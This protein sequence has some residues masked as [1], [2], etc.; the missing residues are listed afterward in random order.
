MYAQPPYGVM[1]IDELKQVPVASW[2]AD[3]CAL[4]LWIVDSHLD[5]GFA[6][7]EAWGF[8]FK[9]KLFS[10][11]K[12]SKSGKPIMGMGHWTRKET[13]QAYL[14]TRGRPKRKSGGVRE[15]II[16]PRREHS[17][18]PDEIYARVEALLDG[19]YLE[20][21]AR[22]RKRGWSAWGNEVGK[23]KRGR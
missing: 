1:S 16:A 19:P 2:A 12:V 11:L 20:L 17:R 18:K 10:W 14:F 21:F 9:T 22:Q 8:K 13:E 5:Q 3:N 23:Y 6:L 7:A 4:I 15:T